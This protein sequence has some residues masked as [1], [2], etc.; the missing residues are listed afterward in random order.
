MQLLEDVSN[1]FHVIFVD[2]NMPG[3]DGMELIRELAELKYT[4]GVVILSKLDKK[5]IQLASDITKKHRINLIG[6][7]SK[8]ITQEKLIPVL[9]KL[10]TMRLVVDNMEEPLTTEELQVSIR[11]K[12]LIPYYQPIINNQTGD[13][14]CLEILARITKP[15]KTD[16][17]PAGQFINKAEREGLIGPLTLRVFETALEESPGISKEFGVDCKLA[18]NIS[19]VLLKDKKLPEKLSQIINKNGY[20]ATNIIIEI[21]ESHAIEETTQFETLNRLRIQGFNLA[22][23]DYGT[24]FTNIQQLKNLPYTEIKIDRSLIYGIH[25]DKLSQVVTSSL[26]SIFKE[27]QVD[28]V[29][30]G[31]ETEEDLNYLNNLSV[32]VHLQGYIISRPKARDNI[33]RW[34]QSWKKTMGKAAHQTHLQNKNIGV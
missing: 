17:I 33:I 32:P 5:I 23:D 18:I 20:S 3:M 25:H 19:P 10:N 7:I 8:P 30:E 11:E 15:G 6:S 22:L 2:L 9:Q 21:T 26:F 12:W 14:S 27:L 29:A 24:G 34:H 1:D 4:G 13:V 28:I 16:A 31:I